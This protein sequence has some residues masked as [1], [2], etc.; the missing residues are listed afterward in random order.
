MGALRDSVKDKYTTK[1]LFSKDPKLEAGKT[2]L[3][4]DAYALCL[5]LETLINV[6]RR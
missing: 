4:N 3:S 6:M 5:Q 1:E 2:E